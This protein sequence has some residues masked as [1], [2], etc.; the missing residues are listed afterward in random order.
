MLVGY[1]VCFLVALQTV[2]NKSCF[3]PSTKVNLPTWNILKGWRETCKAVP[4]QWQ[5]PLLKVPPFMC[6]QCYRLVRWAG[7]DT[8]THNHL[9]SQTS[10][11]VALGRLDT[12]ERSLEG[13]YGPGLELHPSLVLVRKF[14]A[15]WCKISLLGGWT[16]KM[17]E[18]LKSKVNRPWPKSSLG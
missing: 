4:L 17:S 15:E 9:G 1:D 16:M 13:L 3:G 2:W 10:S 6:S 5:L 18:H 14:Q 8:A 7:K 11:P 12:A